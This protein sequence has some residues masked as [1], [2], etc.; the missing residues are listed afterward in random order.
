MNIRKTK[1]IRD[2]KD[3]ERYVTIYSATIFLL[4]ILYFIFFKV[5]V[6]NGSSMNPTLYNNNVEISVNRLYANL[7]RGDIVNIES[8]TLGQNIVKRII[9]IGGDEI[10]CEKGV[11]TINGEI[12]EEDY[13]NNPNDF[14]DSFKIKVPGSQIFVMGDNRGHSVDSRKIGTIP[15]NEVKGKLIFSLGKK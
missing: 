2:N 15:L 11:L 13:V 7:E 3:R 4:I 5:E 1:Q 12:V 10:V 14:N 9:G 6:V 8:K